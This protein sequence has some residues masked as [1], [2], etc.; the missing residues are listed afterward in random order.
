MWKKFLVL[1]LLPFLSCSTDEETL[2]FVGD[3]LIHNW[4]VDACFP[5]RV[6]EN[7]GIIGSGIEDWKNTTAY[8]EKDVVILIGTNDLRK[9]MDVDAYTDKYMDIIEHLRAKRIYLFSLLPRE[10]SIYYDINA[11]IVEVNKSIQQKVKSY[12]QI[13]YLDVHDLFVKDGVLNMEYSFDGL[14]INDL[15]YE[16][17]TKKL[18]KRLK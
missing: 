1:L 7:H 3:S 13:I 11:T 16:I 17:L 8:L 5:T 18:A 4:D 10:E 9:D 6:T 14:H 12:P 15:G 2:Y